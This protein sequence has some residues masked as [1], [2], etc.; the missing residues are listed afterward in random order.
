M[1]NCEF[2][3]DN[4]K[5]SIIFALTTDLIFPHFISLP[6]IRCSVPRN[7]AIIGVRIGCLFPLGLAVE[8]LTY[9][10]GKVARF[11]LLILLKIIYPYS[12]TLKRFLY[13]FVQV[14]L[15]SAATL[16]SRYKKSALPRMVGLIFCYSL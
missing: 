3:F 11:F 1:R 13:I 16:A 9:P 7:S 4:P 5:K 14:R 2:Y 6:R 15:F 8:G 10:R 12:L